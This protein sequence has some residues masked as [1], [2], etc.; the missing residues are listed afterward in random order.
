MNTRH[1][2]IK[3]GPLVVDLICCRNLALRHP[4][5]KRAFTL[6]ELLVVIAII[7]LLVSILLPSLNKAR[8]LAKEVVCAS[9]MRSWGMATHMYSSDY[10]GSVVPFCTAST[11]G[12]S[13]SWYALLRP[14]VGAEGQNVKKEH[15]Q[16]LMECPSGEARFG[17]HYGGSIV[18]GVCGP[19]IWVNSASPS[20]L[21]FDQIRSPGK[22]IMMMDVAATVDFFMFSPNGW[23]FDVD[24]SGD[25]IGD[26]NS[27]VLYAS[28]PHP[29]N[30]AKPLVHR[31]GLNTMMCDGHVQ[32]MDFDTWQNPDNS[33]WK[34]ECS[35]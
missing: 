1:R 16:K 20:P 35:L 7:S 3:P 12:Q 6:I 10:D 11:Y 4:F 14:F 8:D 2:Q 32:W 25:G 30:A 17:V 22:W 33:Y 27:G 28:H 24:E 26:S 29:Y 21:R 19:L 13:R 15:Y 23:G 31:E 18:N 5:N 9:G 34:D